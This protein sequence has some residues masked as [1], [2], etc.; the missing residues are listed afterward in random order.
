MPVEN[1]SEPDANPFAAPQ[2]Q[3]EYLPASQTPTS[4][5]PLRTL[6]KW[7]FVCGI[8]AAPSF[9]WG[10]VIG[11]MQMLQIGA[12]IFGICTFIAGY[13]LAE[14]TAF[15][16]GLNSQPLVR[17][18]LRIGYGTRIAISILF[19]VGLFLDMYVGMLSIQTTR[20]LLSIDI[21]QG[22]VD[23]V[24]F[25]GFY[26]TTLIQ[27]IYL[28]IVLACYMLLVHGIVIMTSNWRLSAA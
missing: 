16:K 20:L 18:T 3:S 9:F 1:Q 24:N 12:M 5:H 6:L 17:R 8:S 23:L 13:T 27:G 11:E 21:G 2:V 7:T 4:K 25:I 22:Q 15:A 14:Y 10:G 19:P 28:N 26:A